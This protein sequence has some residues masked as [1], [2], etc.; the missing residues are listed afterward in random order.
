M[1]DVVRVQCGGSVITVYGD[2][3]DFRGMGQM[4]KY[5]VV[6]CDQGTQTVY[7]PLMF[8]AIAA[9]KLHNPNRDTK[10]A[11]PTAFTFTRFSNP[12]IQEGAKM[13]DT[14]GK[15]RQEDR[16][17]RLGVTADYN[18]VT[19]FQRELGNVSPGNPAGTKKG[20]VQRLVAKHQRFV[21]DAKN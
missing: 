21:R 6:I 10:S 19:A 8:T 11:G 2:R 14:I 4:E 9:K 5:W 1:S 13:V 12:Q 7:G 20:H 15:A 17:K 3:K 18:G 16:H